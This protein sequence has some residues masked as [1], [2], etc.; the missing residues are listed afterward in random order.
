MNSY[1]RFYD[2]AALWLR[3]VLSALGV[4]AFLYRLFKVIMEKAGDSNRL[5]Y[6]ILNVIIGPVIYVVDIIWCAMGRALP[7]CFDDWSN[8]APVAAATVEAEAAEA[9]SAE[10]AP[11]A[12]AA[13]EAPEAPAAEEDGTK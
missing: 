8:P 6:L 11:A 7:L 3:I 4:P 9:P 5:V 2:E 1:I 10:E 13:E 12:E